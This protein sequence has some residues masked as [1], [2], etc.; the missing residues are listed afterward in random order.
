MNQDVYTR[1]TDQIVTALEQGVRPWHKPWE[2]GHAAGPITRPLRFNGAPYSGINVLMLWSQAMERGYTAPIWMTYRQA[3]E[4]GGQVRK[5]EKGTLVVYASALV[6][7]EEDP[8]TGEEIEHSIP[9][10]KGYTV[11]CVEQIDGLPRHYYAPAAAPRLTEVQRRAELEAFF[12][13]TGAEIRHGGNRA[14]Y[15]PTPDV[16]QMPPFTA[17][18]SPES[19]YA[20]LAH[21]TIH[22]TRHPSRLARDMGRKQ[23]GD[24]GYAM[25]ELVA[26]LGAA[27][28]SADLGLT[29]D[30]RDDHVAYI[31]SW[32]GVLRRDTRAIFAAAAHAQRAAY[33]LHDLQPQ[34]EIELDTPFAPEPEA[35]P[36]RDPLHGPPASPEA[37]GDRGP[38]TLTQTMAVCAAPQPAVPARRRAQPPQ[39]PSLGQM[40]LDLPPSP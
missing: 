32:L 12:A 33:Y 5:G 31:D 38:R 36:A 21:E 6:K 23:W 14:Y 40:S 34:P 20:T 15:A 1:I 9:F 19:Y 10:M 25:E 16:I 3:Q 37:R 11:F 24:A 7:T 17:F 8:V 35:Q 27:F 29:P 22:W 13:H 39:R 4:L 28:L 2:A 26:E 30:V 18:E